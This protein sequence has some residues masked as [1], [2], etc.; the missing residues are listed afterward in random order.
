MAAAAIAP[1][2][3]LALIGFVAALSLAM[4][5][6]ANAQPSP[7]A[8]DIPSAEECT[9]EPRSPGAVA[10][11]SGTPSAALGTTVAFAPPIAAPPGEPVDDATMAAITGTIRELIA[12]YNAG[13]DARQGTFYSD[14]FIRR[15]KITTGALPAPFMDVIGAVESTPSP[16]VPDELAAVPTIRD[17]RTL[18]D[19][20][21]GAIVDITDM[22]EIPGLATDI[23]YVFVQVE[24]RWLID[25]IVMV[26]RNSP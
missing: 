25:E 8:G 3:A 19:G 15:A 23:L 2:M 26:E 1:R 13:D 9:I 11:L 4:T 22:P 5:I 18:A 12:C 14:D 17:A 7:V 16:G 21:V 20:R 6:S 10:A 24:D